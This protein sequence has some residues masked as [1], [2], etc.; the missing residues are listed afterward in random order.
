MSI[1]DGVSKLWVLRIDRGALDLHGV[2][3][4]VEAIDHLIR[5]EMVAD[6]SLSNKEK[7]RAAVESALKHMDDPEPAPAHDCDDEDCQRCHHREAWR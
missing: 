1:V 3:D 7:L 5:C 4:R 2:K 6:R